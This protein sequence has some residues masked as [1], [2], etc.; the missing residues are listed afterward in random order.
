MGASS[1]INENSRFEYVFLVY[2]KFDVLGIFTKFKVKFDNQLG[3]H[4]KHFDWI[5]VV[6]VVNSIL[7]IGSMRLYSDSLHQE[8]QCKMEWRKEEIKFW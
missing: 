8:L 1:I 6:C 2:R 7:S 5:K 3:K 4:I